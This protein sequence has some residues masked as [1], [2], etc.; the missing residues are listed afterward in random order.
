MLPRHRHRDLHPETD[1]SGAISHLDAGGIAAPPLRRPRNV[2]TTRGDSY[3]S[4]PVPAH[5]SAPATGSIPDTFEDESI[6]EVASNGPSSLGAHQ[7][8]PASPSAAHQPGELT[9]AHPHDRADTTMARVGHEAPKLRADTADRSLQRR[10]ATAGRLLRTGLSYAEALRL[11]GADRV[12][13]N[14]P[15]MPAWAVEALPDFCDASACFRALRVLAQDGS[16]TRVAR[17]MRGFASLIPLWDA[18]ADP[19]ACDL[20]GEAETHL[21]RLQSQYERDRV[22]LLSTLSACAKLEDALRADGLTEA[23]GSAREVM[24]TLLRVHVGMFADSTV[25]VR[26]ELLHAR[27]LRPHEREELLDHAGNQQGFLARVE[28]ERVATERMRNVRLRIFAAGA[29]DHHT[30]SST[31]PRRGRRPRARRQPWRDCQ[32]GARSPSSEVFASPPSPGHDDREEVKMGD[33]ADSDGAMQAPPTRGF[34]F[35][36]RAPRAD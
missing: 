30:S 8:P 7:P 31:Q 6:S 23:S 36:V 22:M 19:A 1:M 28:L 27:G 29:N 33:S 11:S 13:T 9:A 14:E 25:A 24:Q 3:R 20:E 26:D 17:R 21:R 35:A 2:P 32:R 18:M 10:R 5:T 4:F 12:D 34:R 15:R 16:T